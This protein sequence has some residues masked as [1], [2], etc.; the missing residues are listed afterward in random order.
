M[1]GVPL[2]IPRFWRSMMD[3][4]NDGGRVP[5]PVL[6]QGVTKPVGVNFLSGISMPRS[7]TTKEQ[8]GEGSK[9]KLEPQKG[10]YARSGE[11]TVIGSD[12]RLGH[13]PRKYGR[14]STPGRAAKH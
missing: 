12:Q 10:G 13:I 6:P 5:R 7:A 14:E 3:C 9:S 8:T 11:G 2:M 4:G 1:G